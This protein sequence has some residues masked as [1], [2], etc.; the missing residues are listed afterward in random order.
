MDLTPGPAT[1]APHTRSPFSPTPLDHVTE[2]VTTSIDVD[3]GA[4][5]ALIGGIVGS[6]LLLLICIIVVLL[7]DFYRHK[8]AY[9]TNEMDE[10]DDEDEDESEAALQSRKSLTTKE[11]D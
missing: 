7:W 9:Y 11:D 8:G 6:V 4:F 2:T 10:D 1:A 3:D 5:A